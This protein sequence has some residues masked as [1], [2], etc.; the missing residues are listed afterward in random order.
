M[1]NIRPSAAVLGYHLVGF[2]DVLG[3]SQRLRQLTQ[4]PANEAERDEV[5]AILRNTVGTILTIREMFLNFFDSA[6]ESTTSSE[7][8]TENLRHLIALS[9]KPKINYRGISD[10]FIVTVSLIE[11]EIPST[12]VS[13]I[14]NAFVAAAGMW[15]VGLSMGHPL[16]GA[17]EVGLGMEI[18]DGEVYGPVVSRAYQLESQVAGGPRVVIGETCVAYLEERARSQRD[19]TEVIA[20]AVAS[21]CLSMLRQDHDGVTTLDTLGEV[22]FEIAKAADLGVPG[23][24]DLSAAF[25]PAHAAVR[26]QLIEAERDQNE[27]LIARYGHLLTYF[28]MRASRWS[29]PT[30]PSED[31]T[32]T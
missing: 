23:T 10:S 5:I 28:D 7:T 11:P 32:H 26:S 22:M 4:M 3:Q 8:G 21:R 1:M 14:Y 9:T 13:G 15:L 18:A 31:E 2:F 29:Q 16:R 30:E 17:I 19:I 6:N 27:K 12:P 24:E 20:A 25:R